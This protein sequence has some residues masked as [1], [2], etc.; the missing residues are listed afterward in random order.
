MGWI[1][2]EAG[3]LSAKQ[4][5]SWL[6]LEDWYEEMTANDTKEELAEFAD[7]CIRSA[8]KKAQEIARGVEMQWPSPK[9]IAPTI[10]RGITE[11]IESLLWEE[12]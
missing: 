1:E 3:R 11:Q 8:L 2:T 10:A 7:A 9:D 4:L 5:S 6:H 12:I